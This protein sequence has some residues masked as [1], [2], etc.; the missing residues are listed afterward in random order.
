MDQTVDEFSRAR[1]LQSAP[2]AVIDFVREA[3][4]DHDL[5]EQTAATGFTPSVA[6]VITAG[7]GRQVFVKAGPKKHIGGEAV[8][9]GAELAPVITD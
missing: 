3:L 7:N 8:R 4:D 9:T 2:A 6:S 1:L 5:R